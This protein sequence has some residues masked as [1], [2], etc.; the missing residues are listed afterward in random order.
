MSKGITCLILFLAGCLIVSILAAGNCREPSGTSPLPARL[1][2]PAALVVAENGRRLFTANRRAG[3]VSTLDVESGRV[4]AETA[5]GRRPADLVDG[6]DGRLLAV[7]EAAGEL[8]V[9]TRDK[10]SLFVA[11]RLHVG[12]AAVSV[13]RLAHSLVAVACLWPRRLVLVDLSLPVKP[14]IGK[15]ISLPFAPRKQLALPGGEKI[16]VADAFGGRL[17]VVDA[18]RGSVE[19]VRSVPGHNI[20]GLVLSTDGKQLLLAQQVLT[21]DT[22]TR[23]DDVRWGNVISNGVRSL[24]VADVLK[25]NADLLRYSRFQPL[26]AFRG[27]AADPAGLAVV[28]DK[29]IVALAGTDEVTFEEELRVDWPRLPVGRRPTAIAA[30]KGRVFVANTFADSV[31]VIDGDKRETVAEISLGPTP[32]RTP[33]ERGELLFFD[34]RLS[35][36]SWMSC[37]SCHSDGHTN[38]LRS[39]TMGDGSYGAPKRVPTLLGVAD[40]APWAWNGSMTR[41]EDQVRQSIEKTMHGPRPTKQQVADLTAYLRTLAPPPPRRALADDAV[42]HGEI[43]FRERGCVRCHAP[44]TYTTART[45]EVGL[46]DEMGKKEFNPPSLRGVGQGSAFFHDGRATTLEDVFLRHRHQVPANLPRNELDDLLA[47]L[48]SL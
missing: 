24:P 4:L 37:N 16:V 2:Q 46:E 47:F 13:C 32:K 30:A 31:T 3:T 11:A 8:I 18:E 26:G 48:K 36:E 43:V 41:L 1:R 6:G 44:P 15:S 38:G 42:R 33:A 34:A 19:S 17:A 20:R 27:G 7:D 25:P 5:V 14:R 9:L 22:P 10:D 35:M 40:T 21:E 29:T 23:A 45:Y 28:G 12:D 39:D